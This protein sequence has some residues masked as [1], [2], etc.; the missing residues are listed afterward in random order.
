MQPV[1]SSEQMR[2]CDE[3]TISKI[4][5]PG[6]LLMDRAGTAAAHYI[7]RV[8]PPSTR[9]VVAVLC[10]KG[11]NGGDGFVIGRVL[12]EQGYDVRIVLTC[13]AA[14]IRGD[15]ASHFEILRRIS[16]L[17]GSRISVVP[18]SSF[19]RAIPGRLALVVDAIFGTGF[20]G[21]PRGVQKQAIEWTRTTGVPV[22]A[23]DVPSGIDATTGTASGSHVSASMTITFGLLKAGL[24]LNDGREHAG[25]VTC[26]DIGIPGG[27]VAKA[28]KEAFLVERR[29]VHHLLPRR[30]RRLHKYAAGK[31]L[32]V[33]GSKGYTGAPNLAAHAAL[34]SGAG[35]VTL[36]VPK[37]IYPIMARK[38]TDEI[39]SPVPCSAAGSFSEDSIAAV[40]EK[41]PWADV[42]LIGPGLSLNAGTATFLESILSLY[43]GP[44]VIDADALTLLSRSEK[45][46]KLLRARDWILTPHT[47]EFDRFVSLGAA[48]IERTRIAAA[49]SFSRQNR[50]TLVLKGAPTVVAGPD[51]ACY[52]NPTGNPGMATVG[53]GD[54]LAGCLAAL[55]TQGL[56]SVEA[57]YA[58]TYLHGRAGDLAADVLGERSVV[59][60]DLLQY[61]PV[62]LRECAG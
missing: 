58:A 25:H 8:Y 6:L 47:G 22:V 20:Q 61:L 37:T 41:L 50:S 30:P 24:L 18:F 43:R 15:A 39:V 35:A 4:G 62:A 38:R 7:L 19:R 14:Q 28:D 49:R 59:A 10:G 44:A 16:R 17:P 13:P 31:V 21:R 53:S 57:S 40:A 45:L 52:L 29:D 26:V 33:A 3:T 12:A 54:V 34:R 51:G 5:I 1:V 42:L 11:N 27:V 2:W 23:V 9:D 36:M 48:V 55:R 32:V 46:L 60:S 56:G